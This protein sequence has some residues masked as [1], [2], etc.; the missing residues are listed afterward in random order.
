[1][2]LRFL[3]EFFLGTPTFGTITTTMSNARIIQFGLDLEH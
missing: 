1:M 3:F 2:N